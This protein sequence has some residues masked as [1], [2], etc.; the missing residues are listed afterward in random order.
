MRFEF[1]YDGGAPGSGGNGRLLVDGQLV[2]EMRV[3]RTMPFVFSGDE[4]ADVGI[5]N[6]TPVTEDYAEG[7]NGFTGRIL[8]VVV[9]MTPPGKK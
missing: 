8:K 9:E 4:G 2:G 5:D 7:K 3:K 1:A 6:E